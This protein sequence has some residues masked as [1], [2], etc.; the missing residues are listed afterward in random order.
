MRQHQALYTGASMPSVG[1]GTW[2]SPLGLVGHAVSEALAA[3]YRHIDAA[4]IYQN[5][6]EVGPALAA[7][8]REELFATSKLW[9]NF[10]SARAVRMAFEESLRALRL[11]YLDLY[12]VH[13]AVGDYVEVWREMERLV[14]EGKC[15]AIGVSNFERP[16]LER[17][18]AACRIRPAVIQ[19]ELHPR[20]PRA[21]YVKWCQAQ[22]LV[23]TAYSPLGRGPRGGLL[24]DPVVASVA[25]KHDLPPA[26]VLLKWNLQ[27]NV[28]VIPK[29]VT[30][31]RIRENISPQLWA[32]EL[33]DDDLKAIATLDDGTRFVPFFTNPA[34]AAAAGPA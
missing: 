9:N 30:P 7:V 1:L 34:A 3:G 5:E 19:I 12:L 18:L 14:D 31:A 22:G 16:D 24:D 13:F 28:V 25:K 11:E 26:I 29:S 2:E 23:V 8:P 27:R 33:D 6:S 10:R 20:L 32:F 21:D 17:L 4:W 15:K